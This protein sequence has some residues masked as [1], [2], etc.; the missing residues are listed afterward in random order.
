MNNAKNLVN[1]VLSALNNS[2]GE[3][4]EDAAISAVT[5]LTGDPDLVS[6]D[7]AD[8]ALSVLLNTSGGTLSSDSATTAVSALNSV[9]SATTAHSRVNKASSENRS[10]ARAREKLVSQQVLSVASSLLDSVQVGEGGFS[11]NTTLIKAQKH[12]LAHLRRRMS[13]SG[14]RLQQLAS[15]EDGSGLSMSSDALGS[16]N[17]PSGT[18]VSVASFAVNP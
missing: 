7:A 9:F 12:S 4:N 10:E 17:A 6:E 16:L 1:S 18:T 3:G 15:T 14:R 13:V 2:T 11:I 5:A 8:S